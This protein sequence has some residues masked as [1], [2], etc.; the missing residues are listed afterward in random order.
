MLE[1][2]TRGP[3]AK[4]QTERIPARSSSLMLSYARYA[5][6][7]TDPVESQLTRSAYTRQL[8]LQGRGNNMSAIRTAANKVALT[9][10]AAFTIVVG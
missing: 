8:V 6:R 2:P 7:H 10:V 1:A 3:P 9:A 4:A 5:V